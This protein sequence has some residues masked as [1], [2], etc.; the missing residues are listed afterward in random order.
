MPS[1]STNNKN[2][3]QRKIVI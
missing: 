2:Q 3:L 1:N